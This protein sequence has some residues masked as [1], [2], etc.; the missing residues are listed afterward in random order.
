MYKQINV[1]C[2]AFTVY[3]QNV[4]ISC[5]AVLGKPIAI[6][7][8]NHLP[9]KFVKPCHREIYCIIIH[10]PKVYIKILNNRIVVMYT[11][12]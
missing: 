12:I 11:V 9:I 3:P 5:L 2:F 4:T 8:G 1:D 10:F 7:G 6:L